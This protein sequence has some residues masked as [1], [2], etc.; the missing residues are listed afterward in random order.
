MW[1]AN[2]DTRYKIHDVNAKVSKR[3]SSKW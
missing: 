3:Y 2:A 1:N